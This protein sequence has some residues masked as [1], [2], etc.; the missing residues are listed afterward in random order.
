MLFKIR[1]YADMK[2]LKSISH[3]IFKSHL[4]YATMVSAQNSSS[5]KR[6]LILQKSLRLISFLSRYA[7]IGPPLKN[8]ENLKFS[9][10]VALENCLL[11]SKSY[12][13]TLPKIFFKWFT[14]CFESHTCN[15]R[16][17]NQGCL[18]RFFPSYQNLW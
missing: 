10:K 2:A 8:L 13:K 18:S 14:L 4:S 16:W 12:R 5:V 7:R 3:A 9:D 1:H 6:L 17:A 15:T 11:V